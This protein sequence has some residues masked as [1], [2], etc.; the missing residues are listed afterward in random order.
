MTESLG[1]NCNIQQIRKTKIF[2][3]IDACGGKCLK[4]MVKIGP[5][6]PDKN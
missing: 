6:I 1:S 5:L 4:H 2:T 3:I